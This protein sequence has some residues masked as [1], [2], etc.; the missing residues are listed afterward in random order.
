[1]LTPNASV[2]DA[3]SSFST[4]VCADKESSQQNLGNS[5]N[6]PELYDIKATGDSDI[7]E[8]FALSQK[9]IDLVDDVLTNEKSDHGSGEAERANNFA[10]ALGLL[11]SC[12][13][14]ED[15]RNCR[16]SQVQ[17]TPN[18][19]KLAT[20]PAI[21][22]QSPSIETSSSKPYP[23][24]LKPISR[25]LFPSSP[26]EAILEEEPLLSGSLPT[27][28]DSPLPHTFSP[29]IDSL[30]YSN[31][32]TGTT[33]ST[34]CSP[35]T[36]RRKTIDSGY[37]SYQRAASHQTPYNR[38]SNVEPLLA[39]AVK[40]Q[41]TI[42][43]ALKSAF[44]ASDLHDFNFESTEH[45]SANGSLPPLSS[46]STSMFD[47]LSNLN[48]KTTGITTPMLL[49]PESPVSSHHNYRSYMNTPT[50]IRPLNITPARSTQQQGPQHLEYS[51]CPSEHQANHIHEGKHESQLGP[52]TVAITPA[53]NPIALVPPGNALYT[54]SETQYK[55]SQDD[56]RQEND[57]SD[58]A[59]QAASVTV[60]RADLWGQFRRHD[61][62]M[63]AST[64]GRQM[65]PRLKFMVKGLD[66]NQLYAVWLHFATEDDEGEC[67]K[68]KSSE[69]R[70]EIRPRATTEYGEQQMEVDGEVEYF[71]IDIAQ[72]VSSTSYHNPEMSLLKIQTNP[73]ANSQKRKPKPTP[74]QPHSYMGMHVPS[75]TPGRSYTYSE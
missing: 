61:T 41:I 44:S 34:E 71:R 5:E 54:K 11:G 51:I 48:S 7:N 42:D 27:Y 74:T 23:H 68:W 66:P 30:Q 50:A 13:Q 15:I 39:D 49:P 20:D 67:W 64:K 17:H 14:D 46:L 36:Q 3:L 56:R 19:H 35:P 38:N 32:N 57:E 45:L 6:I 25:K 73:M 9:L 29:S 70:W 60:H 53:S 37:T 52:S 69:G 8:W 59:P 62:E 2:N 31:T 72:F 24:R 47:T 75:D 10:T 58:M 40:R 1:M 43:E 12:L 18:I 65:F 55:Y 33:T 26:D 4:G 22:P 21:A 63:I 28:L 16:Q